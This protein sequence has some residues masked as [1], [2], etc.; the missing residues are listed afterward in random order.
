MLK[1]AK[2]ESEYQKENNKRESVAGLKLNI[3]KT[4]LLSTHA[5]RILEGF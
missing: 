3:R 1:L 4:V 5:P 2:R